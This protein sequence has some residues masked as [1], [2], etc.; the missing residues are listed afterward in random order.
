MDKPIIKKFKPEVHLRLGQFCFLKYQNYQL[1]RPKL[2]TEPG[3]RGF[4]SPSWVEEEDQQHQTP[5]EAHLRQEEEEWLV[6]RV[7]ILVGYDTYLRSLLL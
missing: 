3:L 5:E 2:E 4:L 7:R 6:R 1:F